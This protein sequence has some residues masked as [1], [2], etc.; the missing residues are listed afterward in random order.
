MRL[1][2]RQIEIIRALRDQKAEEDA[3]IFDQLLNGTLPLHR[4]DAAC[5]LISDEFSK[6]GLKDGD[7][8][9][10]YGLEL[11]DLLDVVNRPRL[12]ASDRGA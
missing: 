5:H 10:K 1:S 6:S 2:A 7:E 8:P 12:G 11:E 3:A 4:V 9:T